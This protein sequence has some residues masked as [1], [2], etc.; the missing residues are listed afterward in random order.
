MGAGCTAI[1]CYNSSSKGYTMSRY[2]KDPQLREKWL[3]ALGRPQWTPYKEARVCDVHFSKSQWVKLNIRLRADAVPSKVCIC[4]VAVKRSAKRPPH[5]NNTTPKTAV[6]HD[7]P[8]ALFAKPSC[9]VHIPASVESELFKENCS[10]ESQVHMLEAKLWQSNKTNEEVKGVLSSIENSV[11]TPVKKEYSPAE[12]QRGL[13]LR[14][15]CGSTPYEKVIEVFPRENLPTVRTLNRR[16]EHIKLL[17]G[18]HTQIFEAMAIKFEEF[19]DDRDKDCSF[20]FDEMALQSKI[21]YDAATKS[22]FGYGSLPGD[23]R[24]VAS[25]SECY[26]LRGTRKRWKQLVG[27]NLICKE[28]NNEG[29][30]AALIEV[31]KQAEKINC[32]VLSIVCDMGNRGL[33]SLLGFSTRKDSLKWCIENPV[34]PQK[35]LWCMPD[36]VHVYKSAKE[37]L[38]T[39]GFL[40][41]P[42][43]IVEEYGL[44]SRHVSLEHIQWL[45]K[46]QRDEDLQLVPALT[47]KDLNTTH[48]SKMN[49]KS[50]LTVLGHPTSCAIEYLVVRGLVPQEFETTAWFI[51]LMIRWFQLMTSRTLVVAFGFKDMKKY[52]EA[53]QHLKLVIR[54]FTYSS[55]PGGWKPVQSHII[56]AS[57][58]ALELQEHLLVERKY[59]FVLMGNFS[60][61]VM[62]NVFSVVRLR[63][64]V[65]TPLEFKHRYKQLVL[66][67]YT[68]NIRKSSYDYDEVPC[69]LDNLLDTSKNDSSEMNHEP[70][71]I[72]DYP[73]ISNV[74]PKARPQH[75]DDIL[76]R[77]CG[78]VIHSMKRRKMIKCAKCVSQLS[79]KGSE[80][81]PHAIVVVLMDFKEGAQIQ[82]SD[83]LFQ[84][85]RIVEY[86]IQ[87]WLP[88]LL[89]T[90]IPLNF[91]LEQIIKPKLAHVQ[92]LT[93]HD[94]KNRLLSA[95][96]LMR[97]KQIAFHKLSPLHSTS[98]SSLSSKTV[99]GKYLAERYK[100]GKRKNAAKS[101]TKA[102]TPKRAKP[103][104]KPATATKTAEREP[105]TPAN[106]ASPASA[107]TASNLPTATQSITP[108]SL[109]QQRPTDIG[110][111]AQTTPKVTSPR[112]KLKRLLMP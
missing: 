97:F 2:P 79:H 94:V 37:M 87:K 35:K 50:T 26:M 93:C 12:I 83:S 57:H 67:Q 76:Y 7:H 64:P 33:T 4:E 29:K 110:M 78:Y 39:N 41:L 19:E 65:P 24:E 36:P 81:H 14:F 6:Q 1:N 10:L 9:P 34:N 22:F 58:T 91:V 3:Q 59:N 62:E 27:Y 102:K 49:V 42:E 18:I 88:R 48:F 30:K 109:Q 107:A 99:G 86:N 108:N 66:S 73:W 32:N 82:V 70:F 43:D 111:A 45:E 105:A 101:S 51:K 20:V 98:G 16:T 21:E 52:E 106:A 53:V 80:R 28:G 61:D 100:A 90:R 13:Q 104:T 38:C 31:L 84:L 11:K 40:T 54:V 56:F 23:E 69:L 44:P 89:E 74:P 15:A 17:P 55:I 63:K 72:S 85:L 71:V 112:K 95:F 60:S 8:Y 46:F 96:V 92:L 47:V 77:M 68:Q 75:Q 25:K 5:H 103:P